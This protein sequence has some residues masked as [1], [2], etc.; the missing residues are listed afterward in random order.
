MNVRASPPPLTAIVPVLATFPVFAPTLYTIFPFPLPPAVFTVNHDTDDFAVQ[1]TFAVTPNSLLFA[2]SAP[3]L[4]LSA[5]KSSTAAKPSCFT[6]NTRVSPHPLTVMVPSLGPVPAFAATLYTIFPLPLPPAVLT[7]SHDAPDTAVHDT[8]AVTP[9]SLLLAAS[10]VN[11]RSLAPSSSSASTPFPSCVTVNVCV[12]PHPTTVIF[13]VRVPVPSFSA[14]L[15][16]IDPFPVPPAVFTLNQDAPDCAVHD[17]FAVTPSSFP[18]AASAV[19]LRPPAAS[20][21]TGDTPFPSCVTVKVRTS[22]PPPTLI[23]PLRVPVPSFAATWYA[24]F[25]FPFPPAVATVSHDAP[26]SAVHA[27]S[28]DTSNDLPFAAS[29]VNDRLSAPSFSFASGILRSRQ[30]AAHAAVW[31]RTRVLSL[32]AAV[33][34]GTPA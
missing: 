11:V 8:F 15:Y 3:K 1:A 17:T 23:F 26:D 2:A 6:V 25:P 18:L 14:T 10:A 27:T 30:S 7:V 20:A 21:S 34:T 4:R 19:K 13:P 31:R 12:S 16:P 32:A 22:Q 9:N 29:A 33:P 28:A 5:D 24:I